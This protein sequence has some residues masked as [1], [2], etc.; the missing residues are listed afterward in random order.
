[1]ASINVHSL[2]RHLATDMKKTVAEDA[3]YYIENKPTDQ[4]EIRKNQMK[5]F[6][7]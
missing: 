7:S 1:L 6:V 4:Y 2:R 5:D 3:N